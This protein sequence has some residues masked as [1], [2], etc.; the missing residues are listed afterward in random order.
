MNYSQNQEQET[1][2][3]YFGD[4]IGTFV[5]LGAND[6]ETFSNTRALALK[7]WKGVLIDCSPTA[8]V[9][10]KQLYKD[11]K[12]IYV[13]DYAIHKHNGKDIFQNSGALCTPSDTGLVGTFYQHE[14]E[15]FHRKVSYDPI[16]VKTF[17]WKTALNRWKIKEFDF[18][19]I[20]IEGGEMNV[21]PE[22]DL[23]KTKCICV[24]WNSKP[25]LK[26]EYEK[27]LEGFKLIYT[28]AENLIYGR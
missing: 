18:V 13:Y 24:E 26:A 14:K 21:I 12:D 25:E 16:E 23:S 17:R 9:R 2:L 11:H 20:D 22:M 1:I 8:I 5:D 6:G 15:R 27:Y 19:S 3:N 28:S 7:G 10:C 4:H